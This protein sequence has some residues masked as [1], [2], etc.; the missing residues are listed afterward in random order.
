M[1]YLP[2][3]IRKEHKLQ[4]T[5][6]TRILRGATLLQVLLLMAC[7]EQRGLRTGQ[8]DSPAPADQTTSLPANDDLGDPAQSSSGVVEIKLGSRTYRA[9]ETVRATIT[10]GLIRTIYT[11]DSKTGCSIVTLERQNQTEWEPIVGC[12]VERAPIEF[13][14]GPDRGRDVE[15]DPKSEHFASASDLGPGIYRIR[16]TF[17][18][19]KG[20]EG[21]EANEVISETFEI[22]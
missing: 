6:A 8:Q 14:I 7:A 20:A 15:I 5:M 19:D 10:N 3:R 13:A 16:F 21:G 12:S 18:F 4:T 17:R 1:V 9:G 2:V 11:E 22:R